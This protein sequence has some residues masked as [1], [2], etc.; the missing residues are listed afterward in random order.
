M[1]AMRHRFSE[2][3]LQEYYVNSTLMLE[4]FREDTLTENV[5]ASFP[6]A[7]IFYLYCKC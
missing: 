5:C 4:R 7:T 3:K 1:I 6:K 2:N